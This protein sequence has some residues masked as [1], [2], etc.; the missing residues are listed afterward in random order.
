LKGSGLSYYRY[1]LLPGTTIPSSEI[2]S[3]NLT[4]AP[5]TPQ[6]KHSSIKKEV[7][8]SFLRFLW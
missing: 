8:N 5:E 4:L 2:A 3:N 6:L 1:M 7:Q